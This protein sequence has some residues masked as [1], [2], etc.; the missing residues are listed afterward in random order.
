MGSSELHVEA[1]FTLPIAVKNRHP[2]PSH[3]LKSTTAVRFQKD[4]Y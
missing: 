2:E 3:R 4:A 1:R